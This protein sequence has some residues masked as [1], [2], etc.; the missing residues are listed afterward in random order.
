PAAARPRGQL[1]SFTS[2]ARAK[3]T[4]SCTRSAASATARVTKSGSRASRSRSTCF[5]G[6]CSDRGFDPVELCRPAL[7]CV[8]HLHHRA[9]EETADQKL[10]HPQLEFEIDV[11]IDGAAAI[12]IGREM[13]AIGQ[14]PERPVKI[15]GDDRACRAVEHDAARELLA[16]R[17]EADEHV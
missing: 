14:V 2:P 10:E 13:P 5:A 12:G 6:W 9:V 17:F 7:E 15:F 11:E 8:R 16:K 1:A 4:R 3:A